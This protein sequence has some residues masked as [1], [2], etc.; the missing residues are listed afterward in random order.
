MKDKLDHK[1]S[2]GK[3]QISKNQLGFWILLIR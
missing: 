2:N 1:N 3:T